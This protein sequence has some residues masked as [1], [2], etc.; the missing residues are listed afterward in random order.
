MI[1]V[2]IFLISGFLLLSNPGLTQ[3]Q[4]KVIPT[5]PNSV[6]VELL[7]NSFILYNL[8]YDRIIYKKDRLGFTV[9]LGAQ[10]LPTG[11]NSWDEPITSITTGINMI[12]GRT[13][14]FETGIGFTHINLGISEFDIKYFIP[15]RI[16]VRYQKETGGLFYKAAITPLFR[17]DK[18]FVQETGHPAVIPWLGVAF[19]YSF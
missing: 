18:S 3:D 16:G 5:K 19:G 9:F 7:G 6:Y 14:Y 4:I 10:Y 1:H 2:R 11:D 13:N 17:I 12:I 15:V 8:A